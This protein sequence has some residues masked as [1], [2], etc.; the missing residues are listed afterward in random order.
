MAP[1]LTIG[2]PVYNGENYL[3]TAIDALLAQTF[4]DFELVIS[5]NASTDGT[6]EICRA[7]AAADQRVTYLRQERNLGAAPN[8]NAVFE[9]TESE[10]FMWATHD[11]LKY[12]A[13]VER[14]IAQLDARADIP[15]AYARCEAIDAEGRP[16]EPA[17]PRPELG[18]PDPAVRLERVLRRNDPRWPRNNTYP[19][20]GVIRST[21]IRSTAMHGGYQG[22]DRVFLAELAMRGPFAEVDEV[23]MGYRFH[24]EQSMAAATGA[25]SN[26]DSWFDTS[27]TG[28]G[29]PNWRRH[30]EYLRAVERAPLDRAAKRRCRAVV[31]AGVGR[32]EW[33]YLGADLAAAGRR[34][35]G[36]AVG[37]S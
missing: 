9:G 19:I 1:R 26:R 36:K 5:D 6:E 24:A 17:A 8:Y 31:A 10:L 15:L 23:L 20:F 28:P 30:R 12:P 33:R 14:C 37:R 3:R 34:L 13:Y 16:G 29:W 35:A 2:L 7:A 32:G 11:D 22:S 18:S 27:R 4:L 21:V 25:G